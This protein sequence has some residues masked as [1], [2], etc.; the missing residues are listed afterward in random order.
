MESLLS[1]VIA[2][3]LVVI[4]AG[5]GRRLLRLAG[6]S[7]LSFYAE[8]AYAAGLGLG[9]FSYLVLLLGVMGLLQRPIM[10]GA[11]GLLLVV[12]W[13]D[14][15][16]L[17]RQFGSILKGLAARHNLITYGL[18]GTIGL[19][20]ILNLM[21]SLAP[22]TDA[23]TLVYHL[24]VPKLYVMAGRVMEVPSNIYSYTPFSTQMLY[25]AS[26][27]IRSDI[28]ANLIN[29]SFGC[30]IV[31]IT[32][33]KGRRYFNRHVGLL[34]AL[35]FL[36]MPVTT[37]VMTAARADL[38]ATLYATLSLFALLAYLENN[39]QPWVILSAVFAG[40]TIGAKLQPLFLVVAM[41]GLYALTVI[42][43]SRRRNRQ[44]LWRLLVYG[45]IVGLV[46]SPW[47]LKNLIYTG[48]PVYPQLYGIFGGHY[49]NGQLARELAGLIASKTVGYD[50]RTFLTAPWTIVSMS[51]AGVGCLYL[52]FLPGVCL[53]R[54]RRQLAIRVLGILAFYYVLWFFFIYQRD[55]HFI[56][57][58]PAMAVLVA[59]VFHTLLAKVRV[60]KWARLA[61]GSTFAGGIALMLMV[62]AVYNAKFIPVALG[63]QTRED[64][65]E[66]YA[67]L[68]ESYAYANRHLAM[69]SKVL[70]VGVWD[71]AYYLD[72][73]YVWSNP[74]KQGY[75]DYLS[76]RTE[77]DLLRRLREI[78]ITH[79]LYRRAGPE[80]TDISSS[81]E[82]PLS[83]RNKLLRDLVARYTTRLATFDAQIVGS[84]TLGT[85]R[86]LVT[87][88]LLEVDYAA[89]P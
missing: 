7:F 8:L 69:E 31:A 5:F 20:L 13:R 84:K 25:T 77:Q 16:W 1:L 53:L 17:V 51:Q 47:F 62:C 73:E 23:D 85:G 52:A 75:I 38:G 57:L 89:G 39:Q 48:N 45:A 79:I 68:Y 26:L 49:W 64:F 30:L 82:T 66:R 9:C 67:Y 10:L 37:R 32:Y 12:G 44:E 33:A 88:D 70:L 76:M 80:A 34:A 40:L 54:K 18:M 60:S 42:V 72:R 19:F 24:A 43:Q 78:G 50:W 87:I 22:P 71:Q 4:A 65:L 81:S 27:L 58:A 2:C 21:G 56:Y 41:G 6:I 63:L 14:I 55:R 29:F 3:S 35:V 86:V 46:A 83:I 36:A 61:A 28:V 11:L 59:A 15:L 74:F